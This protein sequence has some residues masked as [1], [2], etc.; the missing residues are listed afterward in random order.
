MNQGCQS[1]MKKLTSSKITSWF[2][3]KKLSP[4][5]KAALKI[6]KLLM[7]NQMRE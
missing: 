7:S 5:K 4:Y 1:L 2:T 3:K 6:N